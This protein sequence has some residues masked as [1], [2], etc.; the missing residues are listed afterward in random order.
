[1]KKVSEYFRK[2]NKRKGQTLV[3]FALV[4]PIFLIMTITVMAVGIAVYTYVSVYTA[5]REA[6]RYAAA[7]GSL[8]SGTLYYQDCDGMRAKATKILPGVNLVVS[9][10]NGIS[11]VILGNCNNNISKSTVKVPLSLGNRV[12]VT[13]SKTISLPFYIFKNNSFSFTTS[14]QS[15]T[16]SSKS[17]RTLIV[18]LDPSI[19]A[20]VRSTPPAPRP[21]LWIFFMKTKF[22]KLQ[23][24]FRKSERG[25]SLIELSGSLVVMLILLAGIFDFGRAVLVKFILQDAAEEGIVYGTS[26]VSDCAEITQRVKDNINTNLVKSTVTVTI[27]INN[28]ICSTDPGDYFNNDTAGNTL[29]ILVHNDFPITMPF[30]GPLL[31]GVKDAQKISLNVTASGVILRSGK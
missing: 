10:D 12:V 25:Q 23:N 5:S 2:E 7:S 17:Y 27:S 26:F 4:L 24:K 14:T 3:E 22:S 20:P 8:A 11:T 9:Y 15:I 13:A 31:G 6:S 19:P 1:M 21:K 16:I 30:I 28:N 29:Q 18:G